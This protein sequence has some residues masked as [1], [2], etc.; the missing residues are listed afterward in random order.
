M[1][2]R[3][4]IKSLFDILEVLGIGKNVL[5]TALERVNFKDFE[6]VPLQ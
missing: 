4:M 6:D 5:L 1:T 3:I 2:I